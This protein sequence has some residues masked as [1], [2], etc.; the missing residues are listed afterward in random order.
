M[1]YTI[2]IFSRKES[3][4]QKDKKSSSKFQFEMGNEE[5][6]FIE[7]RIILGF[8]TP[9]ECDEV[10]RLSAEKGFEAS[11][12]EDRL[13]D[14]TVR[15]S[16]T[17]WLDPQDHPFIRMLYEKVKE[18]PEVILMKDRVFLEHLQVVRYK[19]G[20]FYTSHYD[21]CHEDRPFCI[22]QVKELSGPRKWT[23]LLYLNDD[24]EGGETRFTALD[25]KIK[26]KKGDAL[27]FHSLTT[28]DARVHPLSL[29]QGMPVDRG[30]KWIANV[31]IRSSD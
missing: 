1:A 2:I 11:R 16:E 8:L 14:N 3:Y 21:Q 23:L 6:A 15:T 10:R 4:S 29:H 22:E 24:Y 13:K 26:G 30:E 12:V 27:L 28:D 17:C 7:P 25:R 5:D 20:G 9:E 31:W 19:E 18:L